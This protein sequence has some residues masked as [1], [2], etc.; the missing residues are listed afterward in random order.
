MTLCFALFCSAAWISLWLDRPDREHRSLA[1]LLSLAGALL[2]A[3]AVLL[4]PGASGHAAQTSPRGISVILDWLH[5]ITGSLWLGGLIGLLVLWVSLPEASRV[6]GL[7]VIVPRFSNVAFVSV[8][9]LLGTGTWATVNHMPTMNALWLTGYGV[10]ILVKIGL[11]ICRMALA[12]GNLLWTKPR[13]VAARERPRARRARRRAAAPDG[14]RRGAPDHR[15]RVRSDRALKPR[16]AA[17]RVRATE[18]R[19][20]PT[21]A[22]GASLRPSKKP[23]TCSR[24]SYRRTRQSPPDSF[25]LRISKNGQPLR[26]ANVTLTFNHTEMQMPQQEYQLTETQPG[27]SHPRAT[28]ALVMVG[29][30]ALAFQITPKTGPAVHSAD[31]R[32]GQ[33]MTNPEP[34]T[35]TTSRCG[36]SPPPPQRSP[37]AS[38]RSCSPSCTSEERSREPTHTV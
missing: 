32:P 20:C 28:A 37:P 4:M 16:A 11:L 10:A 7:A 35:H 14:Q 19:A 18:L 33:R 30:W 9:L 26:G 36:C 38:P 6:A 24:C 8:L 15:R 2:A 27:S 3:A 25:A 29:K 21:S 12:A 34:P 1:E 5:L 31:P 17:A 22:P 13:L 23:A